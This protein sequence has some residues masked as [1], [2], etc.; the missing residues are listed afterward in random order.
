M[1]LPNRNVLQMENCW[2]T[3]FNP[4]CDSLLYLHFSYASPCKTISFNG[5]ASAHVNTFD[6][7]NY[8]AAEKIQI[9]AIW[10]IQPQHLRRLNQ[11]FVGDVCSYFECGSMQTEAEDLI[12]CNL[13]WPPTSLVSFI[14]QILPQMSFERFSSPCC[15]HD[16]GNFLNFPNWTIRKW[17][18]I[19]MW[20]SEARESCQSLS[21]FPVEILCSWN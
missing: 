3:I 17:V 9:T 18:W 14:D 21:E 5:N 15:I 2:T 10:S 7:Q 4:F 13:I 20:D 8:F 1:A 12:S 6:A 11:D 16:K 19:E